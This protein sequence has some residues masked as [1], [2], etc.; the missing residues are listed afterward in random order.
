MQI[1]LLILKQSIPHL[2][3]LS[4]LKED[5]EDKDQRL[6]GCQV[7]QQAFDVLSGL[8]PI[9]HVKAHVKIDAASS[10]H[11]LD[12]WN[13]GLA[14]YLHK[15]MYHPMLETLVEPSRVAGLLHEQY[16]EMLHWAFYNGQD[17]P[18]KNRSENLV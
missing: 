14:N 1:C 2:I 4:L 7:I 8:G 3:H 6:H 12:N 17:M 10:L 9:G 5:L 15:E 18:I 13:L 11:K 16:A